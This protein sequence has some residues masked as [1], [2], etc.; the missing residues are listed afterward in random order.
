MLPWARAAHTCRQPH[1]CCEQRIPAR[2]THFRRHFTS[3]GTGRLLTTPTPRAQA[4]RA[5][6]Q[7]TR[8]RVVSKQQTAT[9]AQ[10]KPATKPQRNPISLDQKQL[11]R[12]ADPQAD[13]EQVFSQGIVSD[14][15]QLASKLNTSV[16]SGLS[17]GNQADLGDRARRFG[18]NR[19]PQ[20]K[21]ATFGQLLYE[22]F[23]D[24]TVIILLFCGIFSILV[25]VVVEHQPNGWI[26]G[27]AILAAVAVVTLVTA[28]N[29]YQKEQQFQELN[30]VTQNVQVELSGTMRLLVHYCHMPIW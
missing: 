23:D 2:Q 30:A 4:Q 6:S 16:K 14:V 17:T 27:A 12:L 20:A 18:T 24:P 21:Q 15:H 10:P 7:R 25:E 8:T 11:Q 26:E 5:K 13:P 1:L 9:K 28:G 3:P 19:L 22:A 29:N